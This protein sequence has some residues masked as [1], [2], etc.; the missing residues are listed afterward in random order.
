MRRLSERDSEHDLILYK[1]NKVRISE[2]SARPIP[3]TVIS[4]S[5]RLLSSIKKISSLQ[6]NTT[7]KKQAI[8]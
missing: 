4:L 2:Y 7:L 3:A 1:K 6:K 8:L 5:S